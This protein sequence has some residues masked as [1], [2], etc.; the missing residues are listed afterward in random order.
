MEG[1]ANA[2]D[3]DYGGCMPHGL[4][5]TSDYV[6]W[7][8]GLAEIGWDEYEQIGPTTPTHLRVRK[9]AYDFELAHTKELNEL[10]AS[11][12]FTD[13]SVQMS[14]FGFL[15]SLIEDGKIS[16]GRIVVLFAV[17]GYVSLHCVYSGAP[18]QIGAAVDA[19][20]VFIDSKLMEWVHSNGTFDELLRQNFN[21]ENNTFCTIM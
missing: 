12:D 11:I 8:L 18:H 1:T 6:N 3:D 5:L 9:L 20:C 17:A 13:D 2:P 14:M 4:S 10:I 21:N 19:T 7:R 15:N 16:W